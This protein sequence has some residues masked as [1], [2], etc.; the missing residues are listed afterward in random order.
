MPASDYEDDEI[1]II[2]PACEYEIRKSIGWIR[3]HAQ[4]ECPGCGQVIDIDR[5]FRMPGRTRNPNDPSR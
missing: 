5:N 1:G 3:R 2:C 4:L